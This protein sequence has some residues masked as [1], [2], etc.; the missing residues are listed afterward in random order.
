[1]MYEMC[2]G[3]A[4]P[5]RAQVLLETIQLQTT[6]MPA[7]SAS[8]HPGIKYGAAFDLVISKAMAKKPDERFQTA[9]DF[10]RALT[11]MLDAAESSSSAPGSSNNFKVLAC[12]R[13]EYF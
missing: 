13:P 5:S 9:T 12:M 7:P 8:K 4:A 11:D 3:Q 2:T 1:M 10:K 6:D